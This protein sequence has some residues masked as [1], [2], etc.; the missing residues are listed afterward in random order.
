M[1][2]LLKRRL[3][4]NGLHGVISQKTE[5]FITTAVRTSDPVIYLRKEATSTSD[6]IG[7][8]SRVINVL[9]HVDPLLGNDR[10]I[11]KYTT[12]VSE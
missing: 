1:R 12:A 6:Y 10:E 2:H 11:S 9:W 3:T 8:D 4:F 5:P 7:S